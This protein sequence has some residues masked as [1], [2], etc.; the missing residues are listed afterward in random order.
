MPHP[1]LPLLCP[2]TDY[3]RGYTVDPRQHAAN[4]VLPQNNE[5]DRVRA[6]IPGIETLRN[7]AGLVLKS[8]IVNGPTNLLPESEARLHKISDTY[9]LTP[10][11]ER[12]IRDAGRD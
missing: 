2:F 3:G 11:T 7:K 10:A 5:Y 12:G 6:S 8:T 1:T 9:R 4:R